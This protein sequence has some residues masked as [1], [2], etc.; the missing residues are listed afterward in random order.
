MLVTIK[1]RDTSCKGRPKLQYPDKMKRIG[2]LIPHSKYLQRVSGH[3]NIRSPKIFTVCESRH[4]WKVLP[5][6]S[7]NVA[8]KC[9]EHVYICLSWQK[10][11]LTFSFS[12]SCILIAAWCRQDGREQ[13]VHQRWAKHVRWS[14]QHERRVVQHMPGHQTSR[15]TE[16]WASNQIPQYST[17]WQFHLESIAVEAI[18]E[19][20]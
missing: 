3:V 20:C 16:S 15:P 19:T 2:T 1:G 14:S 8:M 10:W 18:Q 13:S 5:K 4:P 9:Y 11:A 17:V 7:K 6:R 12:S